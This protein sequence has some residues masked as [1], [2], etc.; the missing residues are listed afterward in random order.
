MIEQLPEKQAMMKKMLDD[1]TG[2]GLRS[3]RSNIIMTSRGGS[4]SVSARGNGSVSN[5]V[6]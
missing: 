3:Q 2:G 1:G 5:R 4:Q 6:T